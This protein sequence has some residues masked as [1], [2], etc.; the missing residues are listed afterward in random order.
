MRFP[1]LLVISSILLLV[2]VVACDRVDTD[3]LPVIDS[4]YDIGS[5]T[6]GWAEGH[7]DSLYV[8]G[9]VLSSPAYGEIYITTPLVTTCTLA[10]TFYLVEGTTTSDELQGFTAS[11][12]RLTYTG[13]GTR[14]VLVAAAMSVSSAVNNLVLSTKV[15]KNGADHAASLVLR[16]I[17]VANDVGAQSIATLLTIVSTDYIE[18]YIACDKP[19]TSITFNGMS[20]V[21]AAVD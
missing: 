2:G 18:I 20:L 19:A 5:T 11:N 4:T 6:L 8:G 14:V 3:I 16:K 12:G 9:E 10:D 21:V 1:L 15:Y 17:A 7:F 13:T